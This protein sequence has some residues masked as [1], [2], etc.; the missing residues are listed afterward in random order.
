MNIVCTGR[1]R[2]RRGPGHRRGRRLRPRPAQRAA[3]PRAWPAA[4]TAQR[5]ALEL[6][7]GRCVTHDTRLLLATPERE[8]A[9]GDAAHPGRGAGR[10]GR[11]GGPRRRPGVDGG[12]ESGLTFARER[13]DE[14]P[15]GRRSTRACRR[16]ATTP[17]WPSTRCNGM[18][19]VF[20]ARWSGRHGD[21]EANLRAGAGPDLRCGRRAPR[22][23]RSSAPWRSCCRTGGSSR[24]RPDAGPP[25]PRAARER[26]LRLRP[27]L[28]RRRAR[29]RPAPSSTRRQKDA[30]SHRGKA[31][32]AL[33]PILTEVVSGL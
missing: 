20:S 25:D 21:D 6:P 11:A 24:A 33:V 19:G 22:P 2:L 15:G 1:R 30:I 16:W 4:R 31:L 13:V 18:P 23:R 12:P 32:R 3:R 28:R 17:G 14:G 10:R 29:A 27:D 5:E 8:E 7:H 9:R 26:R